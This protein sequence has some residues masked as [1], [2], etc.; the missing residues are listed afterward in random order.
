M[1]QAAEKLQSSLQQRD[2]N[3]PKKTIGDGMLLTLKRENIVQ[4]SDYIPTSSKG[5]ERM[6][7]DLPSLG[8]VIKQVE[9]E[10][11]VSDAESEGKIAAGNQL[12][13]LSSTKKAISSPS[14]TVEPNIPIMVGSPVK[15][16]KLK[17]EGLLAGKIVPSSVDKKKCKESIEDD[18]D[19]DYDDI[20]QLREEG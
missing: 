2:E 9:K 10:S 12:D 13:V 18:L 5:D 3:T 8:L 17:K 6:Q 7:G 19:F 14:A 15:L 20:E 1:K 4:L 16:A 11:S